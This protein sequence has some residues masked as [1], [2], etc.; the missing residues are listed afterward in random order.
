MGRKR[1]LLIGVADYDP[2]GGFTT[3]KAPLNDIRLLCAVLED[4]KLGDFDSV[5][6]CENPDRKTLEMAIEQFFRT[7]DA[8][9]LCLLY[10]SGHGKF[11]QEAEDAH[12]AAVDTHQDWMQST[13]TS[14]AF[15]RRQL[16]ATICE[17]KV[18]ILDCCTSGAF[19]QDI[20]SKSGINQPKISERH[21]GKGTWVLSASSAF[22]NAY[23]RPT[24]TDSPSGYVSFFT[25]AIVH[26]IRTG[27]AD[28]DG[29]G[30]VTVGEL[31][32]YANRRVLKE[33]RSSAGARQQPTLSRVASDGELVIA[34]NP[35]PPPVEE[36]FPDQAGASKKRTRTLIS[37][38][39]AV[40]I[41]VTSATVA[42][43]NW[44]GTS[45]ESPSS[46]SASSNTPVK[47]RSWKRDTGTSVGPCVAQTGSIYC[48]GYSEEKLYAFNADNGKMKWQ[49]QLDG[50][51]SLEGVP[52]LAEGTVYI[53][54][55]VPEVETSR[56]HAVDS[57][58]G[59]RRWMRPLGTLALEASA[60]YSD[61]MIF[62]SDASDAYGISSKTG[63]I[64]WRRKIGSGN[65][66][67]PVT[68]GGG[69]LYVA[70]GDGIMYALDSSDG[71]VH[72]KEEVTGGVP[73]IAAIA[74]GNVYVGTSNA[75]GSGKIHALDST[76][77]AHKW[78]Y[79]LGEVED[80][81]IV[82]GDLLYTRTE[83]G[84][85]YAISTQ[86]HKPKWVYQSG[87]GFGPRLTFSA[88]SLYVSGDDRA[89]R[90]IDFQSGKEK[91]VYR[92]VE[93]ADLPTVWD[94][95]VFFGA[96]GTLYAVNA[97]DG[98]L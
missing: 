8:D 28:I 34:A 40:A 5:T 59:K 41:I 39:A 31:F 78:S 27:E 47:L 93:A 12:L 74:G 54:V 65:M 37:V 25:E 22:K 67:A 24:D 62:T 94:G 53:G 76:T 73:T 1:A 15:V 4:P 16:A 30:S 92:A 58:S 45:K 97:S 21:F 23:E 71:A 91:W 20:L 38:T 89:V 88:E 46:P 14:A 50:R 10:F 95:T 84:K 26:G 72:W 75:L 66:A 64:V 43:L 87:K 90:A 19:A 96:S 83:D 63:Q 77:G 6:S 11:P 82:V 57:A 49:Y 35:S 55:T 68:D 86:T 70:S 36:M 61:G 60:T 56:I 81:P 79:S 9:D 17:S 69:F 52:L 18:V 85:V 98:Q 13:G 51:P 33:T 32:N 7:A 80:A 44:P 2:G 29:D 48:V 42:A 3:L